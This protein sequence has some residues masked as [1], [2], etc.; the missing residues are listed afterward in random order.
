[1]RRRRWRPPRR[2]AAGKAP[3]DG[4]SALRCAALKERRKWSVWVPFSRG[5]AAADRSLPPCAACFLGGHRAK[6]G[7]MGRIEP[8]LGGSMAIW[9]VEQ[10]NNSWKTARIRAISVTP[11]HA[12]SNDPA[13]NWCG[14]RRCSRSSGGPGTAWPPASPAGGTRSSGFR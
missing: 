14:Q 5:A 8:F 6:G 3:S 4:R 12:G 9:W 7:K 2:A 1:M 10:K 11:A 13:E